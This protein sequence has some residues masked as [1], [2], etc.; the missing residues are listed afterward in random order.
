MNEGKERL[1]MRIDGNR[2]FRYQKA[3]EDPDDL[4]NKQSAE[5]LGELY[6]YIES[7][8]DDHELFRGIDSTIE[9]LEDN[10]EIFTQEEG[11]F[12]SRW[13]FDGLVNPDQFVPEMIAFLKKK[14]TKK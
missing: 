8:P 14:R 11:N 3:E 6:S 2:T 9:A 13:G 12:I 7:L 10:L 5:A 1:L 4:R